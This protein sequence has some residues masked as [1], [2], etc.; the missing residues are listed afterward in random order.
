MLFE[1][2]SADSLTRYVDGAVLDVA[3]HQHGGYHA[4]L[5]YHVGTRMYRVYDHR[6]LVLS[7]AS[8]EVAAAAYNSL[9]PRMETAR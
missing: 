3:T 2:V 6:Q 9:K 7:V 5:K 4:E 8:A 1:P